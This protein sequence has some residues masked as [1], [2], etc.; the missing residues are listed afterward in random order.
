MK[1]NFILGT[2]ISQH[3]DMLKRIVCHDAT[4]LQRI[5]VS[6]LSIFTINLDVTV[7]FSYL[8]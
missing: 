4:E 8:L 1:F 7:I 3:Q 6:Q 5:E 2:S